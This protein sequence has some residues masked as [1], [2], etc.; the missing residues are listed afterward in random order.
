LHGLVVERER[1][2]IESSLNR[3]PI[4]NFY[5]YFLAV[6][7]AFFSVILLIYIDLLS[8]AIG[9]GVSVII[10]I[11]LYFFLP[12]HE[13]Q[14]GVWKVTCDRARFARGDN[15]EFRCERFVNGEIVESITKG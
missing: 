15:I 2:F 14:Y 7:I 5:I 3:T 1:A 10:A 8:S 12:S 9:A 11:I 6:F 13:P 4:Q